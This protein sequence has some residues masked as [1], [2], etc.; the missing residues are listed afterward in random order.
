MLLSWSSTQ[1]GKPVRAGFTN[2]DAALET[3][4]MNEQVQSARKE[5]FMRSVELP[6]ILDLASA[7]RS[8]SVEK[9]LD[10]ARRTTTTFARSL[11]SLQHRDEGG[12]F[13]WV[14]SRRG[15]S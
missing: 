10:S 4:S 12:L 6:A 3:L 14:L 1:P 5:S 7:N 11:E 15:P 2:K 8:P 13:P 9:T